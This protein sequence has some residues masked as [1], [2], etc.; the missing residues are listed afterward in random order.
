MARQKKP[1][2]PATAPTSRAAF[3]EAVK[4]LYPGLYGWAVTYQLPDSSVA[5]C[6]CFR[7]AWLRYFVYLRDELPDCILRTH[8]EKIFGQKHLKWAFSRFAHD[9]NPVALKTLFPECVFSSHAPHLIDGKEFF[10]GNHEIKPPEID[11][12]FWNLPETAFRF[13]EGICDVCTGRVPKHFYCSEMYGSR[14]AQVYGAWIQAE[15]V[16]QGHIDWLNNVDKGGQRKLWNQAEDTI[17]QIIGVPKIGEKFISETILFKTVAILLKGREVI[18]HY[19][20][21]WL[22]RQELD[23]FVPSL[24]LAIEYQGEQHFMPIDAWGREDALK[25]TE[26]RDQEKRR[27]CESNG[28]T[29]LYFDHT[30]ELSEKIVAGRI[31]ETLANRDACPGK[32]PQP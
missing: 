1:T 12:S 20:A 32:S 5:F 11:E 25:M 7:E 28:I 23:I 6:S 29:V 14:V 16:R 10:F 8:R 15:L 27:R 21:D 13:D 31:E 17:R 19:R 22:G 24:N 26:Q 9:I 3:I 18:H 4:P 2:V 30:A